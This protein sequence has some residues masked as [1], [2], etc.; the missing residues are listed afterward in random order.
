MTHVK[1]T[2]LSP[3]PSAYRE[4]FIRMRLSNAEFNLNYKHNKYLM[5]NTVLSLLSSK[6]ALVSFVMAGLFLLLPGYMQAQ[7]QTNQSN[8]YVSVAVAKQR[9]ETETATLKGQIEFL[10][11]GTAEYRTAIWKY[12]LFDAVLNHLYEGKSVPQSVDEG[13]KIYGTDPYADMPASQKR[14]NRAALLVIVH[15]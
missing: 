10:D 14:A 4:V 3:W 15:L 11:P 7:A 13:L 5:K 6:L 9:L 1:P 12:D 2:C 8:Q